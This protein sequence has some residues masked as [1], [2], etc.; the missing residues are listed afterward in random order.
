M[1]LPPAGVSQ[2]AAT[3]SYE[4]DGAPTSVTANT[5]Q[6]VAVGADCES[7]RQVHV[8][9]VI[10]PEADDSLQ[11]RLDRIA[12]EPVPRTGSLRDRWLLCENRVPIPGG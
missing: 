7:S 11:E 1:K 6:C 12:K 4:K 3:E 2:W 8:P 10:V 9:N 5:I